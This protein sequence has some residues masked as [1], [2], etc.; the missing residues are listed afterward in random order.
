M[1]QRGERWSVPEDVAMAKIKTYPVLRNIRGEPSRH[2]ILDR[3]GRRAQS[4]RGLAFWFQ[5]L[6]ASVVEIAC[7]TG[8]S[9]AINQLQAGL[10]IIL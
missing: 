8:V 9:F 6:S 5:P 1:Q 3:R 4:G 7:E 2:V 10:S